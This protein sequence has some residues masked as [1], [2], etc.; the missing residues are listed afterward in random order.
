[1]PIVSPDMVQT[2][3][4]WRS[5]ECPQWSPATNATQLPLPVRRRSPGS[6]CRDCNYHFSLSSRS[7]LPYPPRPKTS[8]ALKVLIEMH[9]HLLS[10]R[11]C[12][13]PPTRT[14]VVPAVC[15][16]VQ[17]IFALSL[18][19]ILVNQAIREPDI[20]EAWDVLA[21]APLSEK[22]TRTASAETPASF[23][24]ATR[25]LSRSSLDPAGDLKFGLKSCS[26]NRA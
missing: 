4:R 21:L 2:S 9:Q 6:Q 8:S 22:F 13:S 11:L 5:P 19:G 1:M 20:W 15:L 25:R 23:S 16:R 17:S 10:C 7:A 24:C 12:R 3:W 18:S 14:R 26:A